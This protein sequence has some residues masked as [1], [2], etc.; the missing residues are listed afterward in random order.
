L[1]ASDIGK[2]IPELCSIFKV[3][4]LYSNRSGDSWKSVSLVLLLLGIQ[5]ENEYVWA[6]NKHFNFLFT[7]FREFLTLK[8]LK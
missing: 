6:R 1:T 5:V 2:A 7:M 3:I 4:T 8:R